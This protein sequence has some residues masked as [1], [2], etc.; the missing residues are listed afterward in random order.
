MRGITTR[1]YSI[2]QLKVDEACQQL[3]VLILDLAS[4]E[5]LLNIKEQI[6]AHL[7]IEKEAGNE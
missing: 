2:N 1:V 7:K 4:G 6:E 3:A 5:K